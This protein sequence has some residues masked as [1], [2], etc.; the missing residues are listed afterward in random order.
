MTQ[1]NDWANYIENLWHFIQ[2]NFIFKK[3]FFAW[4]KLRTSSYFLWIFH[5]ITWC[6]ISSCV[7]GCPL[8]TF[9]AYVWLKSKKKIIITPFINIWQKLYEKQQLGPIRRSH[10]KL[11]SSI[12]IKKIITSFV[13]TRLEK[14]YHCTVHLY[15]V[16]LQFLIP[17]NSITI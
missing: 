11:F 10:V 15:L 7:T 16:L 8:W 5:L 4:H 9:F 1:V 17:E 13:A 14:T 2:T 3:S 6:S 12:R